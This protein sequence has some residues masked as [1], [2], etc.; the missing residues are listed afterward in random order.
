MNADEELSEALR[1][2]LFKENT[3]FNY[4]KKSIR[5]A[6][7]QFDRCDTSTSPEIEES[8]NVSIAGLTDATRRLKEETVLNKETARNIKDWFTG[9][10]QEKN[11][12]QDS[13]HATIAQWF[14]PPVATPDPPVAPATPIV[15]GKPA[16]SFVDRAKGFLG[17]RNLQQDR[18]RAEWDASAEAAAAKPTANPI[19]VATPA[20]R[21]YQAERDNP[22]GTGKGG[23]KRTR[24]YRR[25]V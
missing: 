2:R 3:F 21:I 18:D 17:F 13:N 22:Y 4:L 25:R 14:S 7:N 9:L 20:G 19:T 24:K 1:E 6:V 10:A 12:V 23:R 11:L 5:D 8:V 15:T 16:P